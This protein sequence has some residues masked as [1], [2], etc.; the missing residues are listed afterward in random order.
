METFRG[1][2]WR[3]A[4]FAAA[5]C[6]PFM[7]T[8]WMLGELFWRLVLCLAVLSVPT[9]LLCWTAYTIYHRRSFQH[10]GVLLF[11]NMLLLV[12]ILTLAIEQ[13][14][15]TLYKVI[16]ASYRT[17]FFFSLLFTIIGFYTWS[18]THYLSEANQLQPNDTIER[19]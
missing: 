7:L 11:L 3:I 14:F 1:L 19:S 15:G 18:M 16:E 12:V 13:D 5:L 10:S 6:V 8:G 4:L 9:L 2:L 17:V